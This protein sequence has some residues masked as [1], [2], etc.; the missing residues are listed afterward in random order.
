[1]WRKM[2]KERRVEEPPAPLNPA[3]FT[4]DNVGGYRRRA[5][6]MATMNPPLILPHQ[7]ESFA[8]D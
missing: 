3:F 2:E 5:H 8:F 7:C 6:L 4:D 1:M